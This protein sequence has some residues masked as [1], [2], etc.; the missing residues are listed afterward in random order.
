MQNSLEKEEEKAV[1]ADVKSDPFSFTPNDHPTL[2]D[3]DIQQIK[4]AT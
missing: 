1:V 4:R 2:A 3:K